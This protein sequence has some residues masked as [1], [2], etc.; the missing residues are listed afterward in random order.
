MLPK[1]NKEKKNQKNK[2]KVK[3]TTKIHE[4]VDATVVK[5]DSYNN[6]ALKNNNKE[7][8]KENKTANNNLDNDFSDMDSYSDIETE[9]TLGKYRRKKFHARNNTFGILCLNPNTLKMI[10]IVI[11]TFLLYHYIDDHFLE[12]RMRKNFQSII[13]NLV[14]NNKKYDNEYNQ[15]QKE[16]GNIRA[17][18]LL[19]EAADFVDQVD[20][21]DK[22]L[23][24]NDFHKDEIL[25]KKQQ[26]KE[27]R[28][29]E[30]TVDSKDFQDGLLGTNEGEVE[31][32]SKNLELLNIDLNEKEDIDYNAYN[33]T[34]Q[35][36]TVC[37]RAAHVNQ[38]H[39][40]RF[41]RDFYRQFGGHVKYYLGPEMW[42]HVAKSDEL[43]NSGLYPNKTPCDKKWPVL[44]L[45]HQNEEDLDLKDYPPGHPVIR[46]VV[47]DEACRCQN[48]DGEKVVF[49]E[50]GSSKFPKK[51]MNIP[52]GPRFEFR[53]T[54]KLMRTADPIQRQYPFNFVGS[55]VGPA[56]SAMLK[57]LKNN[58]KKYTWIKDGLVSTTDRWFRNPGTHQGGMKPSAYHKLL[59]NSTFTLC[60]KGFNFDTYRMYEAI[61]SGSIPVLDV[62]PTYRS[63]Q[64]THRSMCQGPLDS[65]IKTKAPFIFLEGWQELPRRLNE[66]LSNPEALR[67]RQAD[68]LVWRKKYFSDIAKNIECRIFQ[69]QKKI[70]GHSDLNLEKYC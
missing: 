53:L 3:P 60:P 47:G 40:S 9:P 52:L 64:S 19:K 66:E 18:S 36:A 69:H 55:S 31:T 30:D 12:N 6:P 41:Y 5:K 28:D 35:E 23:T 39:A 68:M 10:Q 21:V 44:F 46:M 13:N 50:F 15:V 34:W 26:D 61:E 22:A 70:T 11:F 42:H 16:I 25:K 37:I 45:V 43:K 7:I 27:I 8:G 67:K 63:D 14:H 24:Y 49:R 62:G 17:K 20:N 29:A 58:A 33:N 4:D 38:H 57:A 59:L 48:C 51:L 2:R 1:T 54:N 32:I 65:F 56:R